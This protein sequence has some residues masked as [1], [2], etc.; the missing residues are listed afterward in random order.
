MIAGNGARLIGG[1]K[2]DGMVKVFKDIADDKDI[3]NVNISDLSIVD[4]N[5]G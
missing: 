3:K 1:G 2:M 5:N 4:R